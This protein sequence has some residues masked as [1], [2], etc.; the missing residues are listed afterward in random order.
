MA[1][2]AELKMLASANLVEQYKS[3]IW[4]ATPN[5]R[6]IPDVL[7]TSWGL[8][9]DVHANNNQFTFSDFVFYI[10]VL[11]GFALIVPF[12]KKLVKNR[13]FVEI[14][15]LALLP[16][17]S[18][19]VASNILP[20][21][22]ALGDLG[23]IIP[24]ISIFLPRVFLPFVLI[25]TYNLALIFSSIYKANSKVRNSLFF[26][27]LSLI[28][29]LYTFN[30]WRLNVKSIY[31]SSETTH[32]TE[33]IL[34]NVYTNKDDEF[35]IWP[36]IFDGVDPTTYEAEFLADFIAKSKDFAKRA[37]DESVQ[38]ELINGCNLPARSTAYVRKDLEFIDEFRIINKYVQKCFTLKAEDRMYKTW[39]R[40]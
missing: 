15:Y 33:S 1:I 25:L 16:Y 30:N 20:R 31:A 21:L 29:F 10:F 3:G 9:T 26:G 19:I 14:I 12:F 24:N 36:S 37:R 23:S 39:V 35:Y 18:I 7:A 11:F 40:N 34:S 4:I 6:N 2:L 22:S 8:T 5:I 17:I 13:R 32:E 28:F 27:L 38:D